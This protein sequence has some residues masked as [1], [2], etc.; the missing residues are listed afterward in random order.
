MHHIPICIH[1]FF[2]YFHSILDPSQLEFDYC[3]YS[4]AWDLEYSGSSQMQHPA[5]RLQ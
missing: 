3:L 1:I 5:D 4:A 2:A